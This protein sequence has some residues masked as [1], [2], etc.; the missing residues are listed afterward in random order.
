MVHF[1]WKVGREGGGGG[2]GGEGG[3]ALDLRVRA[4]SSFWIT[5]LFESSVSRIV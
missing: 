3:G 2:G 1:L 4:C 5:K